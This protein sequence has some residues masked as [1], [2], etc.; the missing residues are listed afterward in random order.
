[1]AR[2]KA[3]IYLD[4]DI[5][6]AT[7]LAAVTGR[8]SESDIVE[9]ALRRYLRSD[10]AARGREELR[11][12]MDRVSARFDMSEDDAMALAVGE[13]RAHRAEKRD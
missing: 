1:M 6:A 5:R 7:K 13:V 4:S 2:E 8:T 11:E 3:T 12:L 10:D 9:E